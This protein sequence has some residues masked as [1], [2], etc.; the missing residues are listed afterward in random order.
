MALRDMKSDLSKGVGSKQTPQSF[1]DGH[2]STIVTGQKTFGEPPRIIPSPKNLSALSRQSEQLNYEFGNTFVTETILERQTPGLQKYYDRA[3]SQTDP[4]GA[5]NNDKF[6]FDEPFILKAIGDRWGPGGAGVIDFGLVRGGIVTQAARTVADIQRISKFLV[7]P[8]GVAFSLKQDI[9]QKMNSGGELSL[10]TIGGIINTKLGNPIP[11]N[12][13]TMQRVSTGRDVFGSTPP[14]SDFLTGSDIRTWRPTSIIHSLPIGAHYV[15]HQIP[16]GSPSTILLNNVSKLVTNL[17]DGTIQFTGGITDAFSGIVSGVSTNLTTLGDGVSKF[18]RDN[19]KA[20][21]WILGRN[22]SMGATFGDTLLPLQKILTPTFTGL[23]NLLGGLAGK[24]KS[25]LGGLIPNISLPPLPNFPSLPSINLS[26]LGDTFTA[27]SN[28]AKGI[29]PIGPKFT[30]RG[31]LGIGASF[32]G[33]PFRDLSDLRSVVSNPAFHYDLKGDDDNN[34]KKPLTNIYN[35]LTQYA[36]ANTSFMKPTSQADQFGFDGIT[37][38]RIE[39][40]KEGG[41][42]HAVQSGFLFGQKWGVQGLTEKKLFINANI[43]P[44][45]LKI[46]TT[47]NKSGDEEGS[48]LQKYE[49]LAYGSLGKSESYS[50]KVT[51]HDANVT[52]GMGDQGGPNRVVDDGELVRM[53]GKYAG[54]QQDKINLHPYGGTTADPVINDTNIDFVPLKFRDMVNGK[55]II[56]RA[57][58]ESISDTASPDYAEERYIGRPDKVYV[59]QGA[60]RNVNVS[61]KVAPKSVQEL[62]TLWEKLNFLRGLVYPTVTAN[63]MISPFFSFTLG[64]MFDQQPMIFQSL[65]YAIDAASTWE[66]KPGLR[67]PKLINVSA[68]MRVIPKEVPQT[69]GKHYDL[70]W[71]QENLPYG[72]FKNDPALPGSVEP[73]RSGP[74]QSMW[75]ELTDSNIGFDTMDILFAGDAAAAELTATINNLKSSPNFTGIDVPNPI[76][77]FF[78]R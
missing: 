20:P 45:S 2:S 67:L 25:L 23:S 26:G 71:L 40:I 50:K 24:A 46:P 6:G 53:G 73:D 65:N 36:G 3:F 47:V 42:P 22:E 1:V 64:D 72:T 54:L 68:D 27:I 41:L 61:F 7:T 63:R 70:N 5:R 30:G 32:G 77:S 4:I 76:G 49:L 60:D 51:K 74:Y 55:W 37:G 78:K 59:Y 66:I 16:A 58:L 38:I 19:I 44:K 17:G 43:E 56:F 18:F 52:R 10:G 69:T 15:R 21:R 11:T 33:N 31:G 14:T 13:P 8:R 12:L 29:F 75:D 35:E 57:I 48:R 28:V 9:L 62:I 39:G 34:Q